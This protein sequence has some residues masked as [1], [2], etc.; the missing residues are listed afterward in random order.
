MYHN[1]FIQSIEKLKKK[2]GKDDG[3]E[4][5]PAKGIKRPM[6]D[7]M[8]TIPSVPVSI[9]PV[10]TPF[11]T[12]V[13]ALKDNSSDA[14][15]Q[16]DLPAGFFDD[17]V[18]DARERKIVY[19]DPLEEE[20]NK[21]QRVISGESS[22]ADFLVQDELEETQKEKT[23]EEIDKQLN[24]WQKIDQLQKKIENIR[25]IRSQS[26]KSTKSERIEIKSE[27]EEEDFDT[28]LDWR[29]KRNKK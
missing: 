27:D 6:V 1:I 3:E 18:R 24:S 22:K 9:V 5:Q 28:F 2:S 26:M 13:P 10:D 21:F 29:T 20:W 7:R 17:P 25:S 8:V 4:T 15:R 12:S 23:V 19:K 14:V 11:D 16:T